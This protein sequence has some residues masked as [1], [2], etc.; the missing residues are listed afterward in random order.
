MLSK[1]VKGPTSLYFPSKLRKLEDRKDVDYNVFLK[2]CMIIQLRQ[3]HITCIFGRYWQKLVYGHW[4][5]LCW[6]VLFFLF[7]FRELRKLFMAPL[8]KTKGVNKRFPYINEVAS[9][10]YGDNANKNRQKV[11]PDL[12]LRM[13][14]IWNCSCWLSLQSFLIVVNIEPYLST[15]VPHFWFSLFSILVFDNFACGGRGRGGNISIFFS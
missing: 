13:I 8:R 10:K 1:F 11:S 3:P 4:I 9:N 6:L 7:R 2:F 15:L 14:I 5:L 12:V